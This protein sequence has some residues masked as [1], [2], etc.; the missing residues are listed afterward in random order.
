[1]TEGVTPDENEVLLHVDSLEEADPELRC[2]VTGWAE[3]DM[4]MIES[5]RDG[6]RRRGI[7]KIHSHREILFEKVHDEYVHS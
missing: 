4:V 3:K 2:R 6:I 1:M 5:I 7:E